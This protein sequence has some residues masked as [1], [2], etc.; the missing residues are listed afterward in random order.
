[1]TYEHEGHELSHEL[2]PLCGDC[3]DL[4]GVLT[5]HQRKDHFGFVFSAV[6]SVRLMAHVTGKEPSMIVKHFLANP[7]AL[8]K[9]KL[10]WQMDITPA[11]ESQIKKVG[12][13]RAAGIMAPF[14][15]Q[16]LQ[17]IDRELKSKPI[18]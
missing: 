13:L 4:V 9:L 7:D 1:M 18:H 2:Q 3:H 5:D 10:E 15:P 17:A 14:V 6:F 12:L 8:Q 11:I 16:I